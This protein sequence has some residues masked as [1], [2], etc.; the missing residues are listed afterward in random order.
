MTTNFPNL[1]TGGTIKTD[2]HS[3]GQMWIADQSG[4]PAV[5]IKSKSTTDITAAGDKTVMDS[6]QNI[7]D[8]G[9]AITINPSDGAMTPPTGVPTAPPTTRTTTPAATTK[10]TTPPATTTTPAGGTPTFTDNFQGAWNSNFA[11]TDPNND[12]TYDFAAH[13][14]F[15][16]L[17]VPDGNDLA[18][19][20]N[21]DAP[22]LLVPKQGDFTMETL[23]EFD[24]KEEYQGAGL[25]VW[26]DENSFLRLEFGFG[27][28]GGGEK[29]VVFVQQDGGLG[30]VG[31]I[32]LPDTL[33][34]IELR[35][36]RVGNQ[37]T[38]SYRQVGGSWQEI[39]S[40]EFDLNSMVNIGITQVTQYTSSEISADFDY[41]KVFAP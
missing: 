37:F 19:P 31:S 35:V 40:T 29:N 27:G 41:L 17:T 33:K 22:R 38:A 3:I 36:Q 26:L 21:F 34:K 30:L 7:T 18:G 11:W 32:D 5:L 28:M 13:A 23:V 12:V 9:A 2:S 15:L 20:T 16:R 6:E 8:I 4:L 14:G 10:T 39:G 1:Q 25:L 24:P